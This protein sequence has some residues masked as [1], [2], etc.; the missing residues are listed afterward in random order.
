LKKLLSLI[1][2]FALLFCFTACGS[3]DKGGAPE[4]EAP[5]TE[6]PE[7]EAPET[8]PPE[9]ELKTDTLKV[10]LLIN[11]TGWFATVDATNYYEFNGMVDYLNE[12]LGGWK[13]GD[14]LYKI[15]AVNVD[16]QSDP[17]A[18]RAGAISLVDAG[19]K[20]VVETNDF[21][22]A[23]CEDV[24]ED[25][26][27][28]HCSA[29]VTYTADYITE[30]FPLAFTAQNGSVGDF[31]SAMAVLHEVYPDVK[32]VIFAN[33]DTGT[34]EKLYEI[35]RDCG[36]DYGI[37]VLENY[38]KYAGDTTDYSAIA[39]QIVESGADCFMGNGT[40]TA[41]GAILKE[42]R[43]LGSDMVCACVQGKPAAMLM[44][45]AGKEASYNAFTMGPSTREEDKSQN[46]EIFN[47]VIEKLRKLYGDD[48]ADNF[49]GAACNNLYVLLQV[50][51]KAGSIDPKV[52][53]ETWE[54]MGT[55]ETIYGTG[56]TGGLE[57][58]G[59]ANHAIGSPRSVSIIDPAAEGGW[60]FYGWIPTVIP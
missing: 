14:T 11:T 16:G 35:M 46:T 21:W 32:T 6:A 34:N 53:A 22:V 1:L 17:N 28:M 5:K 13:I 2:V 60:Y 45:Y 42:V 20:F 12:E 47:A 57:T 4:T 3:K 15:E 54:N 29:Y 25:A 58:Y 55:V 38:I 43:A 59:V 19:V 39:L 37:D 27:V 9:E 56:T 23:S 40:P 7:T 8:A 36:K 26:G 30:D 31:A 52:V 33:D 51:Q 44:E 10:G 41:Y 24:F 18:I 50:M 49:D 48:V